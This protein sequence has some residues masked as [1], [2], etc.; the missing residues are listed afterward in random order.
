VPAV[1]SSAE[2][3]PQHSW[4]LGL[5][6]DPHLRAGFS[7]WGMIHSV[8]QTDYP[9][10][11]FQVMH[12]GTAVEITRGVADW[13][14]LPPGRLMKCTLQLVSCS[15][16]VAA[17]GQAIPALSGRSAPVAAPERLSALV[18][19]CDSYCNTSSHTHVLRP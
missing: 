15:A 9:L 12:A 10:A 6:T 19:Q 13:Y 18:A 16:L 17:L 14:H 5:A 2:L 1:V 8:L 11:N 4:T 3:P 7:W